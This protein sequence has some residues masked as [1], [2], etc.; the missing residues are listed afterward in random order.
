MRGA[1]AVE[2]D[3]DIVVTDGVDRADIVLGY[4]GAVSRQSDVEAHV[5]RAPR[6][7]EDIRAQQRLAARQ[8][9]DRD[10]EGFQIVH[11][12]KNLFGIELAGKVDIRRGRVAVFAGQVATPDQVPDNHRTAALHHG[13]RFRWHD[14]ALFQCMQVAA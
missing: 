8:N 2:A 6:N 14:G 10:A 12:R 3:A 4:Q 13:F 1:H 7:L 5:L 9:Q 11:H